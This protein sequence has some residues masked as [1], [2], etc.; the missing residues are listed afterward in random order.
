MS[1]RITAA[2]IA[3]LLLAGGCAKSGDILVDGGVGI[4][5]VRSVCPVVGVPAGTGDITL[6]DPPASRDASAIDVSALITNVRGT[7]NDVGADVTSTVTFDVRAR[8]ARA[9][10]ARDV[11]LPYFITI[12]RGGTQV[13]AKRV[14]QV[15]VH[16]DAGQAIASTSAQ[17]SAS[18]SRA[19]ATLPDSVRERLTRKR[20]AGDEDAAIDPL[21][22]PDVRQAVLSASFEALVGFQLTEE[23]LRY[24]AQR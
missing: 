16:F 6:F 18:V 23:Q 22:A 21:S 17:A 11:T 15:T 2:P 9:D 12:V 24:N 14:G 3:L 8:R 7:C 5:S 1:F 19:A 20:K 13:V 10:A 4:S